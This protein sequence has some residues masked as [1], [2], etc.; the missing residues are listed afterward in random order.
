MVDRS[1]AAAAIGLMLAIAGCKPADRHTSS[2]A[3]GPTPGAS[4]AALP[5]PRPTA[6][7]AALGAYVGKYPF[8]KVDGV[9]FLDNPAVTAAVDALVSDA[10]IRKLVL[11]GDGPVTPI[12]PRDGKLIAW[13]CETHNCGD[14]NWTIEIAPDGTAPAVCY[15][16]ANAMNDRSRWHLAPGR[17]EMRAGDCPSD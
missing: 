1:A 3:T 11:G 5:T 6:T 10:G 13:G 14:H 16:D 9:A 7:P 8:D 15:H 17:T 2:N 4:P 12:A